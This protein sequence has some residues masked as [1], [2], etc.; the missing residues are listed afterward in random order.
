MKISNTNTITA[1]R[2]CCLI[3]GESSAGKTFCASTLDNDKTLILSAESGL[4]SLNKFNVDAFDITKNDNGEQIFS[5]I[6]K[7]NRIKEFFAF[8]SSP[9]ARKY[10]NIFVD[11]LTAISEIFVKYTEESNPKLADPK[12]SLM[13]WGQYNN[14]F[15]QFVKLIRDMPHFNVF[16]TCLS[17]KEKDGL[18]MQD[19]FLIAGEQSK[20]NL[21][22][23]FDEVFFL[24]IFDLEDGTKQRYFVT[25]YSEHRLSKDRSGLLEKYELPDLNNIIN[26]ILGEKK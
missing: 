7:M 19:E 20:N 13:K 11:S 15:S 5:S 4:L 10:K 25:D 1:D 8:I 16:F 26:K 12:N 21:K 18:T 24:K 9:E 6:E 3:V 23:W 2:F 17:K 22:S 14:E